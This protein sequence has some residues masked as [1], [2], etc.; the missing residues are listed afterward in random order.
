MEAFTVFSEIPNP[1][2]I[3][4]IAEEKFLYPMWREAHLDVGAALADGK[5]DGSADVSL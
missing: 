1:W 2:Y 5:W 4:Q 3:P